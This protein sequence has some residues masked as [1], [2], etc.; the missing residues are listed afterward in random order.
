MNPTV[1][2]AAAF[3]LVATL[4]F[5]GPLR[6]VWLSVRP[7]EKAKAAGIVQATGNRARDILADLS[8]R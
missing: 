1:A 5:A 3:L 2:A 6:S 8:A 7:A 4:A